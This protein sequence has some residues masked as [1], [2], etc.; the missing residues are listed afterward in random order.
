MYHQKN[1]LASALLSVAVSKP[2][3][4]VRLP[5]S[6]RYQIAS[7]AHE[8]SAVFASMAP[9]LSKPPPLVMH[10]GGMQVRVVIANCTFQQRP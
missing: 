7:V 9:R 5:R 3:S 6:W 4:S 10:T 1:T 2:S 8:T